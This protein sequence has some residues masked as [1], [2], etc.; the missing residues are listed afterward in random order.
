MKAM[1]M[2]NPSSV[3]DN[4]GFKGAGILPQMI[5]GKTLKYRDSR[6]LFNIRFGYQMG[7]MLMNGG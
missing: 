1:T 2:K 7:I 5:L 4:F 6:K 3:P